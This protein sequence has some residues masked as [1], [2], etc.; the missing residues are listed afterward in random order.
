MGSL[1]VLDYLLQR[2][3]G[4]A[5]AIISSPPLEPSGVATPY[6]V[7]VARILSGVLPRVSVDLGLDAASLSR[8]LDVV[9]AYRAD[10][11][12]TSRATVRGA[13]RASPPYVASSRACTPSTSRCSCCTARL[14]D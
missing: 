3:A 14:I 1:V 12:V 2:P 6:L 11:M 9:E 7:A 8:D 10:R 5:G 13:P 4:L